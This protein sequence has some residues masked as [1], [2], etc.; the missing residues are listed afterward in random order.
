L[1][2]KIVLKLSWLVPHEFKYYDMLTNQAEITLRGAKELKNLISDYD[3]INGKRK[4]IKE[5]EREGDANARAIFTSLDKSF[6]TPIDREDIAS[7]VVALDEILDYV[8]GVSDRL[9]L[10][11]V[12]RPTEP[13]KQMVSAILSTSEEVLAIISNLKNKD[14]V[15]DTK[16]RCIK[17]ERQE[18]EMDNLFRSAI[19]E[20]FESDNPIELIK[21]KD[22]YDRLEDAMDKCADVADIVQ[23][24][25]LKYS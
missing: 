24:V 9:V 10:Y 1:G 13:I 25:L 12:E 8:E 15:E 11:K 22:M 3:H 4:M 21:L 7:L 5:I 2:V 17:I 18:H 23:A 16:E 6:I 14:L 20:L 19:G